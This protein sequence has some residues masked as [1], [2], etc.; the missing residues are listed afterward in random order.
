M[1]L[2]QLSSSH[3]AYHDAFQT[4]RAKSTLREVVISY[5]RQAAAHVIHKLITHDAP[6]FR[7]LGV[8]SGDGKPDMEILKAVARGLRS[9]KDGNCKPQIA[10][11]TVEPSSL[12]IADF[13]RSASTLPEEL[14]NLADVSFDWQETTFDGFISE[15]S[16]TSELFHLA[17]F[18]CSLYYMDAEESLK[19]CFKLLTPGGAMFCLVI[20][21]NSFFDILVRQGNL[22]RLPIP[23]FYTGQDVVVIAERNNWKHEELPMTHYEVDITDCFNE[24]SQTGSLLL[25]FLSHTVNFRELADPA[26]YKEM[27]DFITEVSSTDSKG[28]MILRP[29]LSIVVIYK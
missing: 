18:I 15:S 16:W 21:E 3:E 17:H 22:K 19:S 28:K 27:M 26:L 24:S 7:V 13:K 25:D 12:L 2:Q 4:Y 10:A 5:S 11:S 23:G 14:A 1:E 20:K 29:Q 9:S 8:G 6:V